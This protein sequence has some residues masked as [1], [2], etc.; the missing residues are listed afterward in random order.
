MPSHDER[1]RPSDI[2]REAAR[3]M[4]LDGWD[5]SR[6]VSIIRSPRNGRF[7]EPG[8]LNECIFRAYQSLRAGW[9]TMVRAQQAL[10]RMLNLSFGPPE[11]RAW[12]RRDGLTQGRVERT[13]LSAAYQFDNGGLV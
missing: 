10:Y 1:V 11:L 12:E 13:L 2:L 8:T 5:P 4:A 9:Y 7:Y 3:L 6:G